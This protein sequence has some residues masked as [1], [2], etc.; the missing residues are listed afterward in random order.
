MRRLVIYGFILDLNSILY[1]LHRS[2]RTHILGNI[3]FLN[4]HSDLKIIFHMENSESKPKILI[5]HSCFNLAKYICVIVLSKI[6]MVS[7]LSFTIGFCLTFINKYM[8]FTWNIFYKEI[9][10]LSNLKYVYFR[11]FLFINYGWICIFIMI[12]FKKW[13]REYNHWH[14]CLLKADKIFLKVK[15]RNIHFINYMAVSF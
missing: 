15:S 3:V 12:S 10:Y 7:Y 13:F 5:F 1:K 11:S 8:I 6:Y 9:Q 4:P 14:S 2:Q